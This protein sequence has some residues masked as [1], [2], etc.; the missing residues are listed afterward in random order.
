ME[1]EALKQLDQHLRQLQAILLLGA[2]SCFA[3]AS[4]AFLYLIVKRFKK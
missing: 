2:I 4:W 3:L 1:Y